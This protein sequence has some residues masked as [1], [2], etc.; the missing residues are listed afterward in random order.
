MGGLVPSLIMKLV[1]MRRRMRLKTK[2][3]KRVMA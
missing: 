3:K 1:L 2:R